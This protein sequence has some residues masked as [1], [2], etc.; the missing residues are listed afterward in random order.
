ME[1]SGF[2]LSEA[3]EYAFKCQDVY[4]DI[5]SFAAA[6]PIH[7]KG[8]FLIPIRAEVTVASTSRLLA[9]KIAYETSLDGNTPEGD[10]FSYQTFKY[11]D[12][13][14]N[15]PSSEP[16]SIFEINGPDGQT[17]HQEYFYD[18]NIQSPTDTS[19]MSDVDIT[20]Y[21]KYP[22]RTD[23][24]VK[25]SSQHKF[26]LITKYSLTDKYLLTK[27]P[28]K[29]KDNAD[30]CK[31][32]LLAYDSPTRTYTFSVT[33]NTKARTVMV[34][35]VDAENVAASC[36]CEF[37]RWNGPE[38]HAVRNDYALGIPYGNAENPKVRDPEKQYWLCKHAYAVLKR[39]DEYVDEIYEQLVPSSDEELL[40][41]LDENWD[42]L[43]EVVDVPLDEIE[44]DDVEMSWEDAQQVQDQDIQ[45]VEEQV[46]D[47]DIQQ[48]SD[49]DI[50]QIIEGS[51]QQ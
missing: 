9:H 10:L 45:V 18:E 46:S 27:T 44:E 42:K 24:K 49:E 35:M 11:N 4:P 5:V 16:G 23:E 30:S 8:I 48:V 28:D 31:V 15:I 20:Q 37:W 19:Y 1:S 36:D 47:E 21:V 13:E 41:A 3:A 6:I 22:Y 33:G 17:H 43:E 2:I 39:F 7:L 51:Q 14:P 40:E 29:I 38:H 50:Q 32:K 12:N 25:T 26:A 34:A